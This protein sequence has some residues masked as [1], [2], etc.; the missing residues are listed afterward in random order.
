MAEYKTS[1]IVH[2]CTGDCFGAGTDANVYLQL[3]GPNGQ[4]DALKLTYNNETR[5]DTRRD[6]V[7]KFERGRMDKFV[8]RDLPSVGKINEVQIWHDNSGM[9]RGVSDLG[10]A[11][12]RLSKTNPIRQIWGLDPAQLRIYGWAP[13]STA[14]PQ[15]AG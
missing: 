14:I 3:F 4:T 11:F 12:G 1:Y 7:N 5:L 6:L 10:P 2:V 15:W 13:W 9:D 8:F